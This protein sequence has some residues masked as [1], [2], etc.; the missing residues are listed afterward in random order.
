MK[1]RELMAVNMRNAKRSTIISKKREK[2][3][4]SRKNSKIKAEVKE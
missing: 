4:E 2:L 3:V 1:K